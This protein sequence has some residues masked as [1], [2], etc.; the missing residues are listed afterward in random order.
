MTKCQVCGGKPA[1]YTCEVGMKSSRKFECCKKCLEKNRRET[2]I[3]GRFFVS[4]AWKEE[5]C[6]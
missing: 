1:L 2:V 5:A 6:K 3:V 4:C